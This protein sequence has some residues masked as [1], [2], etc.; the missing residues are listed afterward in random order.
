MITFATI[1]EPQ[2][3][4]RLEHLDLSEHFDGIVEVS[5]D[6]AAAALKFNIGNRSVRQRHVDRLADS[7]VSGEWQG[8]HPSPICFSKERLL[9]G[10]HRLLAIV[11]SKTTVLAHVR[12]G[13]RDE[14]RRYI[15]TGK[16]RS[17]RDRYEFFDEPNENKSA[18]AIITTWHALNGKYA[19]QVSECIQLFERNRD[20]ISFA[21][22]FAKKNTVGVT[23]SAVM[24][25]AAQFYYVDKE[26]AHSFAM[27]LVNVDGEVQQ[28]RVLRD[29]LLRHKARAGIDQVDNYG[30]AVYAMK[31]FKD[32]RPVRAL[33]IASWE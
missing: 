21:V 16:V 18:S 32:N 14:L 27:S 12:T 8:D 1:T 10:Q 5:P 33:R 28:A 15:D 9:D 19:P 31:C 6:A 7:I 24:V 29:Y 2:R 23:R 4:L 20:G 26:L 25:A 30:K 3:R 13:V 17:L 11:K 22:Q